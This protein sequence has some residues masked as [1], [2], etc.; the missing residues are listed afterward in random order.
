MT[1]QNKSRNRK[2]LAPKETPAAPV[3]ESVA[4]APR[5]STVAD[6]IRLKLGYFGAQAVYRM[7]SVALLLI[8]AVFIYLLVIFTAV[9]IIPNIAAFI[10]QGTGISIDL[11]PDVVIA[12][13]L[14]PTVF[15]VGMLMVA[16]VVAFKALWRFT[17]GI[18]KKMAVALF[19]IDEEERAAAAIESTTTN[20]TR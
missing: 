12:G 8:L 16:E 19:R 7:A 3:V 13:W 6:K 17:T 4:V 14:L 11:R 10:Q 9:S 18:I 2:P 20:T 1:S 15:V 5:P